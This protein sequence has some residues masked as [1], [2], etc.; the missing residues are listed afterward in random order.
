MRYFSCALFILVCCSLRTYAQNNEEA[1]RIFAEAYQFSQQK[2]FSSALQ[3]FKEVL[4]LMPEH[5]NGQIMASWCYLIRGDYQNATLHADNALMLDQ[6]YDVPY[7]SKAYVLLATNDPQAEQYL[8]A[9]FFLSITTDAVDNILKD[10]DD[11][12]NAGINPEVFRKLKQNVHQ[13]SENRDKSFQRVGQA[14]TNAVQYAQQQNFEASV[15]ECE[16][17]IKESVFS[18]PYGYVKALVLVQVGKLFALYNYPQVSYAAFELA[19]AELPKHRVISPL[20]RIIVATRMAEFYYNAFDDQKIYAL[21][22]SYV[23]HA[24]AVPAVFGMDKGQFFLFLVRSIAERADKRDE[25]IQYGKL[26]TQCEAADR[27]TNARLKAFGHMF[28]GMGYE[29]G[30]TQSDINSSRENFDNAIQIATS[31]GLSE[32]VADAKAMYAM[33]FFKVGQYDRAFTLTNESTNFALQK[34]DYI[35]A[36]TRINNLGAMYYAANNHRNAVKVF[37]RSV[38][39]AEE[40]R[41]ELDGELKLNFMSQNQASYS[42][43]VSSLTAL[44]DSEGL[45]EIQNLQRGRVLAELLG[46]KDAGN[47]TNLAQYQSL[48]AADE[49]TIIYSQMAPGQMI[50]HL[51][52]SNQSYAVQVDQTDVF[53]SLKQRYLDRISSAAKKPGYKPVNQQEP[54]FSQ[55]SQNDVDDMMQLTRE[56]LQSNDAAIAPIRREFLRTY[57]DLLIAPI[58]SRLNGIKKVIMMPDGIFNFLPFE[59]L[60]G[61]DAK[62][63]V[64]RLD[65][66]YAQS[67]E[68]KTIISRRNYQHQPKALLAMGGA[69]YQNMRETAERIR[70]VDKMM[71]LQSQA[72]YN[73][74]IKRPQREIYAALGFGQLNYLPGTLA[75]VQTISKLVK[76]P[77]DVFTGE[78]MT[79]NKIKAM[80]ASGELKNYKIV[81][82]A[83]HGFAIP[84]IPQLSGVAMCIFPTMQGSEDGYLTAPEISQLDM[85][86]ELAILSACETGL[87]K[88]YGGEGVTGLTQSLLVGGANRAIVSLWPVSDEG[89]MHFMTGLYDLTENKGK[90]YDEAVNIMKRKFINGEFGTAFTATNIWAPFVHYGK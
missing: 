57:N 42:F 79:E 28:L 71:A 37:R 26:L 43:L 81:H 89:T 29:T 1:D 64:E 8:K 18:E 84:Q 45:F 6:I 20:T 80:A 61:P 65:I 9:Y 31:A 72:A 77:V 67:P 7:L 35:T 14:I 19:L 90:T 12:I 49:A 56:L 62:Y 2:D 17:A 88:I 47:L 69:I 52:T 34:K 23:R 53:L 58:A 54:S 78:Q 21:L 10:C 33:Y 60:I 63:L 59:T 3:G 75:E 44:G 50:I 85:H 27:V 76:E 4:R 40:I 82:L 38:D 22:S 15:K 30:N 5:T 68:V 24:N 87:G 66:R 70:G 46:K 13:L 41:N 11:L 39:M 16:I 86:A 73:T 25:V 32:V 51:V 55:L 48:L 83:T 36:Q 74:F